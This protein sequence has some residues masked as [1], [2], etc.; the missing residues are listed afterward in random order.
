MS[1]IGGDNL[2]RLEFNCVFDLAETLLKMFNASTEY[3]AISV[4]GHYDVIKCLL[5]DL[6]MSGVEIANEIEL[7][8]YSVSN[9]DKEFVLYLTERGVN[10]EKTYNDNTYIYGSCD[11]SFVHENCNSKLLDYAESKTVYEF[12]ITEYN[13]DES[14]FDEDEYMEEDNCKEVCCHK[15]CCGCHEDNNLVMENDKFPPLFHFTE[16]YFV[17]GVPTSREIFDEYD[18]ILRL[19]MSEMLDEMDEWRKLFR[20]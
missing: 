12:G 19:R 17:N 14:D 16:R 13:K 9:Y 15:C 6:I 20:W 5:E 3:S 10:V 11:I 1:K 2:K 7:Q 8:E 4:Y 18:K